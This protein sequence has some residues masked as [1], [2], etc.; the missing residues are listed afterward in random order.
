M[1]FIQT[2][3]SRHAWELLGRFHVLLIHFPIALLITPAILEVLSR[4]RRKVVPL[5]PSAAAPACLIIGA[6]AAIASA[7]TGWAHADYTRFP[8]QLD[9]LFYHR[10]L[11][12]AS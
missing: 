10:W 8:D 1:Q 3:F 7:T 6:L 4:L 12:I 11:G 9:T 5:A 2:L